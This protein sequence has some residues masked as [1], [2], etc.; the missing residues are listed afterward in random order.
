MSTHVSNIILYIAVI[1]FA[2]IGMCLSIVV[3]LK[4][5]FNRKTLR[6]YPIDCL[7]FANSYFVLLGVF[8]FFLDMCISSIY[9]YLYP[10][11]SFDGFWCRFKSYLTYIHGYVYFYSFL[12]QAIYRF[13]RI[14]YHTQT[15]FQSFRLYAIASIFLWI[16][17]F[18]QMLP[19]LFL[20]HINY[21][22]NEFHCQFPLTYLE[23][24]LIG[25]SI[26]FLI[27]HILTLVCYLYTMYCVRK[28]SSELGT[29]NQRFNTKRDF[30]IFKRIVA[31]F[32]IVT[33]SAIPHVIIPVSYAIFGLLSSWVC[34]FQWLVTVIALNGVAVIQIFMFP[35]LRKLF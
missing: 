18:W 16:N 15:K 26:M 19:S 24:S 27:P 3:L 30:I 4:M 12:L 23:G 29:I 14:I 10:H 22:P 6:K 34:P 32:T 31:L 2:F 9:G 11:S 28:R 1:I 13:Y 33:L 35:F 17:G 25:L 21:I 5:F 20:G 7:L 8:P